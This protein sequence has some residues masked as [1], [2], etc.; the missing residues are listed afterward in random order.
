MV[1]RLSPAPRHSVARKFYVE[2]NLIE[3][4]SRALRYC[5]TRVLDDDSHRT[6]RSIACATTRTRNICTCS[7]VAVGLSQRLRQ[8]LKGVKARD[9][10]I[11]L[12]I[13]DGSG[14]NIALPRQFRF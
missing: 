7:E 1:R 5:S 4:D 8:K 6:G 13:P 12:P 2:T 14:C 3:R 9:Y 10:A 11:L